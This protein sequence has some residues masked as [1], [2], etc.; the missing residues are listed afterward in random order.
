MSTSHEKIKILTQG[1]ID[2]PLT[3]EANNP[4][5]LMGSST[6]ENSFR[7]QERGV[8]VPNET[9]NP[10]LDPHNGERCYD[11]TNNAELRQFLVDLQIPVDNAGIGVVAHTDEKT[12][13][14]RP[15]FNENH[16]NTWQELA[17]R[18]QIAVVGKWKESE[19]CHC[20]DISTI[21]IG[22]Q[23]HCNELAKDK[24]QQCYI[25]IDSFQVE[26]Q[27]NLERNLELTGTEV[28]YRVY[29]TIREITPND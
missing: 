1:F 13:T 26:P 8:N 11:F 12:H 3:H 24:K 5:D 18:E 25:F 17:A 2:L 20:L 27:D 6:A 4:Y 28:R 10:R 9:V 14:F 19:N 7:I 15:V 16:H 21:E 29:N 22:T 23:H